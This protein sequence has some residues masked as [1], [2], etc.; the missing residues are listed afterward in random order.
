MSV[1]I[2]SLKY[3]AVVFFFLAV[4]SAF[5]VLALPGPE[6]WTRFKAW[7][8]S[9][10]AQG[11]TRPEPRP[12]ADLL[13][14]R[15]WWCWS[16]WGSLS[17]MVLGL[18]VGSLYSLGSM[19][20]ATLVLAL[21]GF[22][23][24]RWVWAWHVRE[25]RRRLE[26]QLPDVLEWLAH[27]LRAGLSMVQ[28]LEAVGQEGPLPIAGEFLEVVRDIRLGLS[29]EDALEKMNARW[30]HADLELFVMAVNVAGRTGGD[31]ASVTEHIVSTIRE[32]V[33]LKGRITTLTAQGVLSGWIV[34]L[35]PLALLLVIYLMDPEM[36]G[37]FMTHPLGL[38]MLAAGAVMELMGIVLIRRI[39]DID[40]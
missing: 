33:R 17:G 28:S 23:G 38:L 20:G 24:P 31:L 4:M 32:R 25:R 19:F 6:T 9:R 3:S 13:N 18:V 26:A 7:V 1:W 2:M 16:F 11:I 30:K 35:L 8:K 12:T 21:L 14:P 40:V 15:S 37:G 22:V 34:G 39:V 29:P 27:S 5:S 36:I 10:Y